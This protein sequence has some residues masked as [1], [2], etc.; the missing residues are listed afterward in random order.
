ME[1]KKWLLAY[2]DL[3]RLLIQCLIVFGFMS[4]ALSIMGSTKSTTSTATFD[5]LAL[6]IDTYPNTKTIIN[7]P[8][9]DPQAISLTEAFRS[10]LSEY[11]T[12]PIDFD[13]DFTSYVLQEV[14][15]S[16]I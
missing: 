9:T 16:L 14:N 8:G 5:A 11:K 3:G 6:K 15:K 12:E 7:H 1:Y 4:S 10:T 13:S 2:R